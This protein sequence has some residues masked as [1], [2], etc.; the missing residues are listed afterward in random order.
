MQNGDGP[1]STYRNERKVVFLICVL[2]AVHV[3]IFSAAFP[4]FNNVDEPIHFDLIV[5]YSHGHLPWGKQM[6]SPDSAAYLALFA[7]CAYFGTPDE[8]PGGK[9]PAPP[10]TEPAQ[11]MQQDLVAN[12]AAWQSQ[13]NYEVSQPPLYYVFT[14][15]AWRLGQSLHADAGHLLYWLR[16]LNIAVIVALVYL[17]YLAARLVFP[18][19]Y[20]PAARRSARAGADAANCLLLSWQRHPFTAIFWRCFRLPSEMVGKTFGLNC[21]FDG[22]RHG[23]HLAF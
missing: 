9:M 21:R 19:K 22:A 7:S 11:K 1:P 14:G 8:F 16:F 5:K 2:A 13:E 10:W 18:G 12:S 6:I 4:F 15:V 23:C 17:A 20:F 3:F